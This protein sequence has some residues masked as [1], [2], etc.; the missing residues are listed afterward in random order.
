MPK[1]LSNKN[2][3]DAKILSPLRHSSSATTIEGL[4][5]EQLT[6]FGINPNT[7]LGKKLSAITTPL[8]ESHCHIEDL[9]ILT[10]SQLKTLNQSD[11]IAYF[12]AKRFICFQIAKLLDTFAQPLRKSYQS[13]ITRTSTHAAKGPYALIDNI[14]ALF[15]A[16]PVITKTATYLYACTE[17]IDDAFQGK[18]PLHSIYSRLLNP[19]AISL[20]NYIIDIC[21]G[22]QADQYLAWNFNAGM[23]ALDAIFS[24]LLDHSDILISSRNIYGGTHQLLHDWFSK[25]TKLNINLCWFD[26]YTKNE[27]IKTLNSVQKK[28]AAQLKKGR[29]IHIFLESP[30][31]PHGYSLDVAGICEEAHK[32]DCYVIYDGTIGTPFLC[33]VLKHKDNSK[34]PDFVIHSYTKDLTGTGTTTAGVLIGRN[35]HMFLPKNQN[36]TFTEHSIKKTIHWNNTVFWNVYYIK[37]AFLD[38]EKAFSV[39]NGIHTLS[40]RMI[41]KCINTLFLAN[42]LHQHPDINVH[43]NAIDAHSNATLRK[44]HHYLELPAP[45]FTID[46][47]GKKQKGIFNTNQF[48]AFFDQLEPMFGLQVSL[49]QTNTVIL[50][51]ALTSHSEL[52]KNALKDASISP[53]TIRISVGDEDP[54]LLLQHI[55]AVAQTVFDP[56]KKGFSTQFISKKEQDRLYKK[57]YLDVHKNYIENQ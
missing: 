20:A 50:C 37:G 44:K 14:P 38:A 39:I 40:I 30:C 4:V 42:A 8:Y 54:R 57:I 2:I 52:S 34:K 41:K 43:S 7:V 1:K 5:T 49:G 15:S 12:N 19:T 10:L 56:I 31:N 51:P 29:K 17:W 55:I 45:L 26:G 24:H 3:N 25:K 11:K 18:E 22:D 13:L 33:P 6:H 27:F 32:H 46:F 16:T 23:S 47:E 48:K 36:V 9:Y 35:E 21:A 28:Y 53:T